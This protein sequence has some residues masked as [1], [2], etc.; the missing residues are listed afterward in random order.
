MR[1][2]RRRFPCQYTV[3]MGRQTAGL[4]GNGQAAVRPP[5]VLASAATGI[6]EDIERQGGDV[7]GVFASAAIAP[8]VA[9]APTLRLRLAS[10]C[11]LFEGAARSTGNDNFGL[12]FGNSFRPR[13]LGMWGYSAISAQTLGCAI[14][15]LVELF[16]LHQESSL[17]RLVAGNSLGRLEYQ[18]TV[19]SILERRQD[20]ELSLGM[21]LNVFRECLGARWVPEEIHF[22]HPRPE[23]FREHERA[24]GAPVYF[25]QATNAILFRSETLDRPMPGRDPTLM[26]MMR[27]CLERLASGQPESSS[28]LDQIRTAIRAKLASGH[29]TIE[30]IAADLRLPPSAIHRALADAGATHKGLVETTRR[31]L[32]FMYMKQRRLPLSEIALLTGYSELSAFSRA[33]R[34]WTGKAPRTLR[35]DLLTSSPMLQAIPVISG[36]HRR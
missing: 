30:E 33:V 26:A 6:V 27:A 11:A 12:W 32:A 21:F 10:F 2:A 9:G 7:E 29:P 28:M 22:E 4:E 17:M 31:D 24:F 25:S 20:A 1:L 15:N 36:R 23:G 13:D 3:P 19:P 34:R 18:I 16:P 8:S 14:E 5:A 35:A